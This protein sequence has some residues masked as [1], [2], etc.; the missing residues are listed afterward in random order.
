MGRKGKGQ[1]AQEERKAEE[2]TQI[3]PESQARQYV[4]PEA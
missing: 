1:G 2:E 3:Q 4:Q